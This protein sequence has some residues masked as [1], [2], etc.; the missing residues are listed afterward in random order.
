M[1]MKRLLYFL[2]LSFA[3]PAL[4]AQVINVDGVSG[5]GSYQISSYPGNFINY[6][7]G[8]SV[9]FRSNHICPAN[10]ILTIGGG[11][12]R[13]IV[14]TAGNPLSAGDIQ[15][16]QVVT[17]IY[18]NV[19]TEFQMISAS[20]NAGGGA[21]TG[22]GT[23]SYLSRWA[24]ASTLNSSIIYDTGTEVRI[25]TTGLGGNAFADV[26]EILGSAEISGPLYLSNGAGI[27]MEQLG[28]NTGDFAWRG[29]IRTNGNSGNPQVKIFRESGARPSEDL[30]QIFTDNSTTRAFTIDGNGNV[31]VGVVAPARELEVSKS[32]GTNTSLQISNPGFAVGRGV[33]IDFSISG[34]YV[35][36][37]S[38][39]LASNYDFSIDNMYNNGS[40][41]I[42]FKTN[43][44]TLTEKMRIDNDGTVKIG[45]AQQF[46]VNSSGNIIKLNNVITSF[47]AA[48]AVGVLTNDGAGNLSWASGGGGIAGSGWLNY[49]PKF[50][51]DGTT[52]GNSNIFDDGT[53]VGVGT[54][55]PLV[56]LHVKGTAT[57]GQQGYVR[58]ED[59]DPTGLS[60]LELRNN[61]G[62]SFYMYKLSTGYP[63]SGR[64]VPGVS[65]IEGSDA[66]GLSIVEST[67]DI[68][69]YTGANGVPERMTIKNSGNVGIGT[70]SP[71][72][73]LDARGASDKLT[74]A[75]ENI[76][77]VASTDAAGPLALRMGIQTHATPANMYGSIEVDEAG[78]K[79]KLHLQPN[80][81]NLS[82]GDVS[83]I[84]GTSFDVYGTRSEFH[85]P[86][87][88]MDV[89]VTGS[90]LN[91][92][93]VT[94]DGSV[95]I[96]NTGQYYYSAAKACTTRIPAPEFVGGN[97]GGSL[98]ASYVPIYQSNGNFV[99]FSSQGSIGMVA[100]LTA[101]LILPD[102]ATIT[103]FDARVYDNDAT[104]GYDVTV[105]LYRGLAN[106]G[107]A[108][109]TTTLA[110]ITTS[111]TLP[112]IQNLTS[113]FIG[114]TISYTNQHYFFNV[115]L[116]QNNANLRLYTILVY[117]T[118]TKT[119]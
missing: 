5:G 71:L 15:L 47:P 83:G 79:R 20:G 14:N 32:Q 63:S 19:N 113:G 56:R 70:P 28:G 8:F 12:P 82:V 50:T 64:Y 60:T 78:T 91:A 36:K 39:N 68:H 61:V 77:Q 100:N 43:N 34:G 4:K 118:V 84:V 75:Y 46:Q 1:S 107:T 40:T 16:G 102:G 25:G 30:M 87:G 76:F 119:D 98:P 58:V 88:G 53:Y 111:A 6:Y 17:V 67:G 24:T 35:G 95:T 96:H 21:I 69:F 41:G 55:T 27:G 31:G 92:S 93:S 62:A 9:I 80:G 97:I 81:G 10:P 103:S 74:T 85:N 18:D 7:D 89:Y 94:V 114:E 57:P 90:L 49:I 101:P 116:R 42:S 11:G 109:S 106:I 105:A 104:I 38:Q 22:G 44:A 2:L 23:A 52:L 117:Y 99:N 115:T 13:P 112:N 54:A 26:V 72:L 110:T 37:I 29:Q 59:V 45:T 86:S 108:G 65:M 48:N 3:S 51:P 33:A 66:N 73:K